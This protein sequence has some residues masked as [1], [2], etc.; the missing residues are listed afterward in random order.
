[1]LKI[2]LLFIGYL[3]ASSSYAQ[4]V[5]QL[6]YVQGT[7]QTEGKM[8]IPAQYYTEKTVVKLA[9]KLA[10]FYD[11]LKKELGTILND[12]QDEIGKLRIPVRVT[13]FKCCVSSFTSFLA[14]HKRPYPVFYPATI[15]S[16]E[17]SDELKIPLNASLA[18]QF[19]DINEH[20]FRL[21]SLPIIREDANGKSW[22]ALHKAIEHIQTIDKRNLLEPFFFYTV[23]TDKTPPK[24]LAER[25]IQIMDTAE[26][27]AQIA[28]WVSLLKQK[29]PKPNK[30]AKEIMLSL[31]SDFVYELCGYPDE[32]NFK[33]WLKENFA[34]DL[35]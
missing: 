6:L 35:A 15:L 26:L 21:R 16:F 10:I 24:L 4:S 2:K 20:K 11:T 8:L 12:R 3:F 17:P 5:Y 30:E 23:A 9:G 1:M 29:Y 19:W 13:G 25:S 34:L 31:L 14:H 28:I 7:I 18:Y 32:Y 27:K 33:R 22:I